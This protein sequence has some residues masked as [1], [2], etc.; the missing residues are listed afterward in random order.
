MAHCGVLCLVQEY[1]FELSQRDEIYHSCQESCGCCFQA[2]HRPSLCEELGWKCGFDFFLSVDVL[3]MELKCL[4]K[5]GSEYFLFSFFI[6]SN[7][8]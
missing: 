7:L 6:K 4:I 8:L 3:L 5:C 1:L 2:P